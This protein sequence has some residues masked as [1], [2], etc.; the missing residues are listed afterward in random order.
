MT[1]KNK[2]SQKRTLENPI[3]ISLKEVRGMITIDPYG[4][5][6][7]AKTKAPNNK[8]LFDAGG[9]VFQLVFHGASPFNQD[10]ISDTTGVVTI[11][12]RAE[13]GNYRYAVAILSS[14]G[15]EVFL[16]AD[17]PTIIVQ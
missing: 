4:V 13:P 14:S 6:M 17:C 5:Y 8:A 12:D 16:E 11:R 1:N 2:Q 7:S 3:P 9:R 10:T 15:D